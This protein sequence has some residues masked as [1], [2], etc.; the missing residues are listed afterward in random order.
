MWGGG[1]SAEKVKCLQSLKLAPKIVGTGLQRPSP[2]L[3]GE[4]LNRQSWPGMHKIHAEP[5][6]DAQ[7]Q[8]MIQ[9][10]K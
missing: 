3:V 8:E 7:V 6:I 9:L 4:Y 10:E 2:T 1:E 5:T